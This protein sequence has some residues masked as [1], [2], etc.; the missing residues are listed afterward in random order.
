[1][2]NFKDKQLKI[3]IEEYLW[4]EFDKFCEENDLQKSQLLRSAIRRIIGETSEGSLYYRDLE[5]RRE[6]LSMIHRNG[7]N[8]NQIAHKLNIA[9]MSK[10]LTEKDKTAIREAVE[11]CKNL[12][13]IQMQETDYIAKNIN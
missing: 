12:L 11:E 13:Y 8:I 7:V 4:D 3:R 2:Y 9:M 5:I 1:M 10:Y 6:L